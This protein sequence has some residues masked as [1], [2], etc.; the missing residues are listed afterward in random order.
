MVHAGIGKV[1]DSASAGSAGRVLVIFPGSL[2]DFLCFCPA[3]Q[4][5]GTRHGRETVEL[6]GR[7]EAMELAVGWSF[8]AAIHSIDGYEIAQLFSRTNEVRK[9]TGSFFSR[10]NAVYSWTAYGC[11]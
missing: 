2:G 9:E 1:N 11:P 8:V 7:G 4:A 10:F 6:V 5:M 3:L